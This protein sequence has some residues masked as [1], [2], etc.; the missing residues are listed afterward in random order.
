MWELFTCMCVCVCECVCEH[1]FMQSEISCKI[2]CIETFIICFALIFQAN[3]PLGGKAVTTETLQ[4]CI[5]SGVEHPH[6]V[7]SEQREEERDR[8]RERERVGEEMAVL[9]ILR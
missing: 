4:R 5:Q 3:K 2:L 1:K 9:P 7:Q 6:Q 8:E